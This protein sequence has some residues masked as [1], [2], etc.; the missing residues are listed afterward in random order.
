MLGEENI[1]GGGTGLVKILRSWDLGSMEQKQW[2]SWRKKE[3]AK[4]SIVGLIGG[5]RSWTVF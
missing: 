2:A 5:L 4:A 3:E 1:P